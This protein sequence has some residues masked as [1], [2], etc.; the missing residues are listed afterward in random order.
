MSIEVMENTAM[1]AHCPPLKWWVTIFQGGFNTIQ[2]AAEPKSAYTS[3]VQR[4]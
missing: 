1:N 2:K 4:W 3:T